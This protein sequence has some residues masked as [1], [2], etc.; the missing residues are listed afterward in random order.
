M[1]QQN[2]DEL[3]MLQLQ[4]AVDELNLKLVK[5]ADEH[6]KQNTQASQGWQERLQQETTRFEREVLPEL[7]QRHEERIKHCRSEM[8]QYKDF[9][10]KMAEENRAIQSQHAQV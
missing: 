1:E 8:M 4:A 3:K 9:K 10:D 6:K 7:E 5:Q 2:E